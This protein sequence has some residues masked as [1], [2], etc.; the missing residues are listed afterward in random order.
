MPASSLTSL[1]TASYNEKQGLRRSL[2][3][4]SKP[5]MFNSDLLPAGKTHMF[6]P[7][8]SG[9]SIHVKGSNLACLTVIWV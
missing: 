1:F 6:V 2:N 4:N 8:C 3:A 9:F 7:F 5:I